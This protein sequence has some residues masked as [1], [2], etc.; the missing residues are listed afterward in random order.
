MLISS[1]PSSL[2]DRLLGRRRSR[3]ETKGFDTARKEGGGKG[4]EG[5]GIT[6]ERGS[7]RE[8]EIERAEWKAGRE[9]EKEERGEKENE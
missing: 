8:R 5:E 7:E 9:R 4:G 6:L 3:R 1:F 2:I